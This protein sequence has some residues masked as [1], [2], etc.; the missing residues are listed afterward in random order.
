MRNEEVMNR[1]GCCLEIS[2]S[3]DDVAHDSS[4]RESPLEESSGAAHGEKSSEYG[5]SSDDQCITINPFMSNIVR[6]VH[7]SHVEARQGMWDMRLRMST[8][9]QNAVRVATED[10][11]CCVLSGNKFSVDI[12]WTIYPPRY[13]S[14]ELMMTPSGWRTKGES[15]S[16]RPQAKTSVTA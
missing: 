16:E 2:H 3:A 7:T 15:H 6:P 10:I 1:R 13:P 12:A 11:S 5:C 9:H 4:W 8:T 14:L